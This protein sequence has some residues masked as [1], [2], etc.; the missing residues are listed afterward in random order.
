MLN[1]S[2]PRCL[3][4][5]LCSA[6][7]YCSVRCPA[8]GGIASSNLHPT[9]A[10]VTQ[11]LGERVVVSVDTFERSMH[12]NLWTSVWQDRGMRHATSALT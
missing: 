2:I 4:R 11:D 9:C 7:Y 5:R 6:M 3:M 1:G 10:S 8:E 12:L